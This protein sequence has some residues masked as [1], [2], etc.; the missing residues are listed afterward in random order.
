MSIVE[1]LGNNTLKVEIE[2]HKYLYSYQPDISLL[3]Y[4]L[5]LYLEFRIFKNLE[6]VRL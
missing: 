1:I 2:N 3:K 6:S 4:S 5:P